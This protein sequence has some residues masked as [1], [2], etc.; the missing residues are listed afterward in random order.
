MHSTLG[1][2]SVFRKALVFVQGEHE[3]VRLIDIGSPDA[4]PIPD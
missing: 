2:A 3:R 4:Q 1:R